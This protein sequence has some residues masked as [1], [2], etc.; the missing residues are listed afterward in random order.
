[1][2]FEYMGAVRMAGTRVTTAT[3]TRDALRS[4]FAWDL[5]WMQNTSRST[6]RGGSLEI[7][8]SADGTRIA[9]KAKQRWWLD[10]DLVVDASA[11]PLLT[12]FQRGG[13]EGQVTSMGAT[14]DV[15][16]GRARLGLL[17]LSADAA[18]QGD[19][20]QLALHGG[21]RT[22][23]RGAVIVSIGAIVGTIVLLAA[24]GSGGY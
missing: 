10:H 17:T 2:L 11:G 4:W 15:G 12:A 24:L 1:M 18:R 13:I 22:E 8:G 6:S 21:V 20:M 14:G 9:A 19:R 23:S 3:E 5:G 7:G 16:I